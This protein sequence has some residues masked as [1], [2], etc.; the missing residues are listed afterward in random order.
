MDDKQKLKERMLSS[1]SLERPSAHDKL[2]QEAFD[3]YKKKTGDYEVSLQ[4]G[5]CFRK[6]T[7]WLKK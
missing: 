2:W 4:C 7:Q 3:L 5:G 1:G 6:V